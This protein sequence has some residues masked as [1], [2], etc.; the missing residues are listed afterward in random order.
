MNK[1]PRF[2]Y[3]QDEQGNVHSFASKKLR[4]ELWMEDKIS[5]LTKA[6]AIVATKEIG[7]YLH[8]ATNWQT[9]VVIQGHL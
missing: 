1:K 5:P 7:G 6:E 2:Y 8:H 3:G 9:Y 4:D